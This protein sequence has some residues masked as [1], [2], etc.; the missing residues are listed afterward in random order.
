MFDNAEYQNVID[1]INKIS[2]NGLHKMLTIPQIA[3]LGDQSSGKYSV[4]KAITKLSF[5]RNIDTCTRF[6]TKMSLRRGEQARMSAYIDNEPDF[7]K[8]Y[9]T[10]DAASNIHPAISRANRSL[11]SNM[12]VSEKVLESPS[13]D[14]RCFL[15]PSSTSLATSTPPLMDRTSEAEPYDPNNERCTIPIV[16]KS[17]TI[18][19]DLLSSLHYKS[20][21]TKQDHEDAS[22]D[23]TTDSDDGS[24]DFE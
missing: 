4:I 23:H 11:C 7:N 20:A 14:Q 3:I 5:P 24:D 8:R 9:H 22:D 6:A 19:L 12:D 13:Q 2:G 1:K 16:T 15:L 17:D 10:Q 21:F 18:E